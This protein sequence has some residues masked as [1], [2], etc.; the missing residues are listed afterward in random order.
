MS[1]GKSQ[2]LEQ[3]LG[4]VVQRAGLELWGLEYAPQSGTSLLR[5]YLDH[6]ERPVTIEDCEQVSRE[7][8]A[9]LDVHDPISGEYALEVSSPGVDRPLFH[10]A[11]YARHVGV[12][13]KLETLLPISGRRRFRGILSAVEGDT[14]TLV[15]DALPHTLAIRDI[16]K[17]RIVPDYAEL[18]RSAKSKNRSQ[19][20]SS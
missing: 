18:M 10:A 3:L 5:I 16:A 6:P 4:P 11:Q 2:E 13:V 9:L 7:I 20:P 8:S 1:T 12:E 15:V 19:T 17:A 14:I